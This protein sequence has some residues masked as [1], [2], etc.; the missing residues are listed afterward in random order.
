MLNVNTVTSFIG[1]IPDKTVDENLSE[2]EKV[3]KPILEYAADKKVRIAIENCP[4][5][6][7]EDEWPGG[8]NLMTSPSNWR[9]IFQILDY[10]N[11]GLNYDPSHF[12]CSR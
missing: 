5:L 11:L 8:Q 6:F 7:T 10:D 3:W 2:M 1:R 12:V 4:M 9:K